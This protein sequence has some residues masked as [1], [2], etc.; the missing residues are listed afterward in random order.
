MSSHDGIM[1]DTNVFNRIADG[2]ADVSAFEGHPLFATHVQMDE[3]GN[4]S[5]SARKAKLL[6]CFKAVAAEPLLTESSV[7]GVSSWG[8]GKWST[9]ELCRIIFDAIQDRDGKARP[10][11]Q[12]RDALIAETALKNELTL[13]SEDFGL[14]EVVRAM[15]GRAKNLSQFMEQSAKLQS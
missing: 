7:W 8:K 14:C 2:S 9:G 15:G 11:N 3:L 5:D 12:W 4:T 13:L 6:S 1:L 10:G